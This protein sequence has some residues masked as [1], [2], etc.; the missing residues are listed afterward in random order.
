M[1]SYLWVVLLIGLSPSLSAETVQVAP[2]SVTEWKSVYG[3][4]ETR[5]RV[6]ARARIGGTVT[7]LDVAEGDTVSAGARI[8]VIEDVKLTFQIDALDA[9]LESLAARL[10]TARSDLTRG[11][12]L[13]ERGVITNR[14]FEELQTAVDVLEGEISSLES[15]RSVVEQQIK[16][17]DVLAPGDGIVLS[18]P[19]SLGSVS[20]PG[21]VIAEIGG[22]GTFLR[23]ALPERHARNLSEG[24]RIEIEGAEGARNGTLAKVYPLIEGGRVQADVEVDGLDARFIGRRVLVRLPVGERKAILVP[25]STLSRNGGLDFVTVQSEDDLIRRVVVPGETLTRDGAKWREILTGLEPGDV[26]VTPDE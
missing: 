18:V 15:E 3:N 25:E 16:E 23:L 10:A 6:P 20:A 1:K 14:R 7:K 11:E 19:A 17:G 22:G 2:I 8:A 13:I 4:V 9:R 5:N 21:E 12:Q 24:D 26:V